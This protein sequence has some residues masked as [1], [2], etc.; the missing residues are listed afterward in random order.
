MINTYKYQLRELNTQRKENKDVIKNTKHENED[1]EKNIE[2]L[3]KQNEKMA[4]AIRRV[5][6]NPELAA[7]VDQKAGHNEVE[8]HVKSVELDRLKKEVIAEDRKK[9]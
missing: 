7:Q 8:D 4:K 1:M 2:Y 3:R 6:D 9:I 5:K